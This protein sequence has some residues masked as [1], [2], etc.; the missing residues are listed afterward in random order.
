MENSTKTAKIIGKPFKKGESG[1]LNGRPKGQRNFANIYRDALI[2]LAKK[3]NLEPDE[4]ETELLEKAI[5]S[6]RKGDHRFYK[7]L[8]D[9]LHG[10]ATQ[11]SDVNVKGNVVISFDESFNEPPR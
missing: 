1:N 3:N 10:Q 2:N 4:L 7:D 6:A 11:N 8:M 5:F 9:R